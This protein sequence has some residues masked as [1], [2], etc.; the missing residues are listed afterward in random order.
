MQSIVKP[1]W[2][3]EGARADFVAQLPADPA[4]RI[5]E[6]GCSGGGTGALALAQGRCA[7]YHAIELDEA[8]AARAR[9]RLSEVLVLDVEE[10]YDLPWP[11]GHF[12]ALIM[13]EVIEH[14]RDPWAVL[15]RLGALIRPGGMLL[16]S[17]PNVS[18][19]HFLKRVW[20]QRWD[21]EAAGIMDVTHLR[22]FTPNSYQT[23]VESAGFR[24][25]CVGPIKPF[26]LWDRLRGFLCGG[27]MH[28]FMKQIQIRAHKR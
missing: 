26:D 22:W 27:R 6:I 8:S 1:A 5:L 11:E 14:L 2:Y 21:P 24:V 18:H 25:A 7:S 3:F 17:S 10:M 4:A 28:L 19:Y 23:L 15:E 12:D 20:N 9:E 16:C 13:S